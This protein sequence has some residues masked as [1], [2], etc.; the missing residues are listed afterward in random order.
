MGTE[1]TNQHDL[2]IGNDKQIFVKTLT[3]KINQSEQNPDKQIFVETLTEKTNQPDLN[4]SNDK[5]IIVETLTER[6][7]QSVQ[8]IDEAINELN[9]E[10]TINYLAQSIADHIQ[11][12]STVQIIDK[13]MTGETI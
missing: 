13:T 4:A 3:E 10:K 2:N 12:E 5:Q 1:K 9:N 11:K 7:N 8:T 6:S